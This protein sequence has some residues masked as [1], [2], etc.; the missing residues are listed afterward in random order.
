MVTIVKPDWEIP[1]HVHAFTSTRL[2]G[3]SDYPFQY[4]NLGQQIG[5]R[6]TQVELNRKNFIVNQKMPSEPIWLQQTH[7]NRVLD[8]STNQDRHA[9]AAIS[10]EHGKVL[11]ILTADCLPILI[12]NHSG[13]E[14]AAIHAGWRGLCNGIIENTL[15]AMHSNPQQ[16]TAW[17]GPSICGHCFEVGEEVCQQFKDNYDYAN[18]YCFLQSKW[19]I[20]LDKLAAHILHTNGVKSIKQSNLCTFE[21]KKLFYS[22]RRDGQTGRIG[23]FIWFA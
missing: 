8:V 21:Q 3:Q 10:R 11:A 5:D 7:S 6:D 14:I 4:A 9:D 13:T 20:H 18:R 22:Y 23:T 2:S 15:V 19:H 1:K 12:T 16:C 17:I